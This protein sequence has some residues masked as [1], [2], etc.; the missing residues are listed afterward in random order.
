[1]SY[2]SSLAS[3]FLV[4]PVT[5]IAVP[6]KNQPFLLQT[7]VNYVPRNAVI[8]VRSEDGM[9]EGDAALDNIHNYVGGRLVNPI[10]CLSERTMKINA[11]YTD[12]FKAIKRLAR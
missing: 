7:R 6:G 4:N 5:N 8:Y 9:L 10:L 2:N 11:A 3:K 12:I 1:M